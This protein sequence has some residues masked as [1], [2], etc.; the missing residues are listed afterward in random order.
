MRTHKHQIG[1]M[2]EFRRLIETQIA[3][4][5][6]ERRTEEDLQLLTGQSRPADE[7]QTTVVRWHFDFHEA[8]AKAA[9]NRYL[10][11]AMFS[12]RSELFVPV[13]WGMTHARIV[14][15]EHV[16]DK[17]LEAVRA[18]DPA[19]AAKEMHAHLDFSEAPFRE[20]LET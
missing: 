4:L 17:I 2:L 10:E 14:D 1:E 3:S 11:Q 9:H 7:D 12:I 6:A 13:E 19:R 20:A 16:H 15:I 18:G 8:L 5:A